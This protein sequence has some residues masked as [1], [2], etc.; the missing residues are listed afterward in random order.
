MKAK[1][2]SFTMDNLNYLLQKSKNKEY[3][4]RDSIITTPN[5]KSIEYSN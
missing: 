2:R 5:S 3:P 4:K 1:F